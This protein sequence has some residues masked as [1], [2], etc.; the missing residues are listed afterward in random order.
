M[1]GS[2]KRS[3]LRRRTWTIVVLFVVSIFLTAAYFYS[4]SATCIFFASEACREQDRL[5]NIFPRE[6]TDAE[7]ESRVVT[8]EFLK[9]PPVHSK[10]PKI[11]FLFLTPG[12]LP[13]EKLWHVFFQVRHYYSINFPFMSSFMSMDA[14]FLSSY[15]F[16]HAC[17]CFLQD[18]DV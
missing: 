3:H 5:S 14:I 8:K 2:R 17:H 15:I 18:L 12:S 7:I 16:I 9:S 6:L 10:N 1:F 13:F 4:S 11:A